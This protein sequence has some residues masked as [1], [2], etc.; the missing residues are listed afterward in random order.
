M[1]CRCTADH[2]FS[3]GRMSRIVTCPIGFSYRPNSEAPTRPAR[4]LRKGAWGPFRGS[5]GVVDAG[6]GDRVARCVAHAT[7]VRGHEAEKFAGELHHVPGGVTAAAKL[8]VDRLREDREGSGV[9]GAG[10]RVKGERHGGY[11]CVGGNR[12]PE[13]ASKWPARSPLTT[14]RARI[15]N[16]GQIARSRAIPRGAPRR[17]TPRTAVLDRYARR[18]LPTGTPDPRRLLRGAWSHSSFASSWYRAA[19]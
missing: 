4:G 1:A 12:R 6:R 9:T 16:L 18:A 13:R 17:A 5:G 7:Y 11:G 10:G 14:L 2:R 3:V 8:P 19:R 15:C